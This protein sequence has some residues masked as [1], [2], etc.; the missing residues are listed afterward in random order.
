MAD[1]VLN[2]AH[3]DNSDRK[4]KLKLPSARRHQIISFESRDDKFKPGMF[5]KQAVRKRKHKNLKWAYSRPTVLKRHEEVSMHNTLQRILS[6]HPFLLFQGP[7]ILH[8]DLSLYTTKMGRW[9][10]I[11]RPSESE[12]IEAKT[13]F[14]HNESQ[15]CG[16]WTP[17]KCGLEGWG[18][19]YTPTAEVT[20]FEFCNQEGENID[21]VASSRENMAVLHTCK[22]QKCI[23]QCPCTIC[24]N[25]ED[26]CCKNCKKSKCKECNYQCKDHQI[27]LPWTFNADTDQYTLITTKT[28]FYHFATPYAGIPADCASC[29]EDLLQHQILHLVVHLR[30][31]YCCQEFR[32]YEQEFIV[33]KSDYNRTETKMIIDEERTCSICFLE[34]HDK[35]S[36]KRHEKKSHLI[37]LEKTHAC[38]L[39]NK[40][41][42]N[43]NALE[44]HYKAKHQERA[45]LKSTAIKDKQSAE[46]ARKKVKFEGEKF[47]CED[48]GKSLK[49]EKSLNLHRKLVHR[50]TSKNLDYVPDHYLQFD[51]C[52]CTSKFLRKAELRRHKDT[53]HKERT[54]WKLTIC[55]SCGT[56][57]SRKDNFIR[58]LKTN[59]C[60]N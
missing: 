58:H 14:N 47:K 1:F 60:K 32:P 21:G 27:K 29:T 28:E 40:S 51:C 17:L 19:I 3:S 42:T 43:K 44:Y 53:V 57:F 15:E 9:E 25:T 36:R 7:L 55:P 6:K 10:D 31:K 2:G 48:C 59:T 45:Q 24:M 50:Y 13:I 23:I 20:T 22:F 12:M 56:K 52:E 34:C 11:N 16:K 33:T 5:I 18:N 4:L 41:Y 35:T 39:C 30:C 46:G 26:R 54:T 37:V 38:N 49:F 8:L